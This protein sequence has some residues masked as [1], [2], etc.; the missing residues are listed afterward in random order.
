MTCDDA[1]KLMR[2]GAISDEDYQ[3][4]LVLKDPAD[5]GRAVLRRNRVKMAR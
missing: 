5:I 3:K 4:F 2:A 1:K